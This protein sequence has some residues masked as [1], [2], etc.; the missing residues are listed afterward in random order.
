[1]SPSDVEVGAPTTSLLK[2]GEVADRV[3]LS[4]RTIRYYEEVGLL[5][6]T[7]RSP[8]GF[9]LYSEDQVTRLA[10]LKGYANGRN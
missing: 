6:P 5:E 7:G 10:T 3:G 4:L 1:M 8:G 2:I 9:R